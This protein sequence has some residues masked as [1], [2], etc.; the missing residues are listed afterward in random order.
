[1]KE[2]ETSNPFSHSNITISRKNVISK[3][4][5]NPPLKQLLDLISDQILQEQSKKSAKNFIKLVGNVI[6]KDDTKTQ[7]VSKFMNLMLFQ[8]GAVINLKTDDLQKQEKHKFESDKMF[9]E[10]RV[11]QNL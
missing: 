6:K 5:S 1:M 2:L 8:K 3:I 4:Y 10:I 9:Q 7:A 11:Y